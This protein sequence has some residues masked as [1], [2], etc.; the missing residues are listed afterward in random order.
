MGA[1]K[2]IYRIRN[3]EP[4]DWSSYVKLHHEAEKVDEAG[5]TPSP[6]VFKEH[7][8]CPNYSPDKNLFIA[9][10]KDDLV[11]CM[12]VTPETGIGRVVLHCLVHPY[13]RQQGLASSLLSYAYKRARVL[14]VK[15]A[16]INIHQDNEVGKV[17]LVKRGFKYIRK[18]LEM[19]KNLAE[20]S[21]AEKDLSSS[22]IEYRHLQPGQED[23]LT[24]LQNQAF[25]GSWGFNPN[26]VE[27]IA[28]RTNLKDSS[29]EDVIL[30]Y[31]DGQPAGYCWTNREPGASKGKIHMM[32]VAPAYR[33]MK[34]GKGLLKKALSYLKEKGIQKVELT[35]DSNNQQAYHLYC[36]LGFKV[37]TTTLWY[38]KTLQ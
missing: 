32:G 4:S 22:P 24:R 23:M 26:T 3:Y 16:H 5:F 9:E 37:W 13:H 38:E 21:P 14:D 28:Y 10:T 25:A 20:T 6:R 34:L 11:G 19:Q 1:K 15:L 31:L 17:V 18:F 2:N 33:G 8:Q 12:N 30:A 29:A 7:L 27:E 36:S 35:V